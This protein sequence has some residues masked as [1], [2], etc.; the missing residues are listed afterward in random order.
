MGESVYGNLHTFCSILL[1]TKNYSK[2]IN[3]IHFVKAAAI[4]Q[5]GLLHSGHP[6]SS[7]RLAPLQLNP[8]AL[9]CTAPSF[10]LDFSSPLFPVFP[11]S[12]CY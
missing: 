1:G 9:A 8:P 6:Q 4:E 7:A 2:K 10:S 12:T 11:Y 3:F 5:F